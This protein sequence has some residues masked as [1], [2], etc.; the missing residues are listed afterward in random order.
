MTITLVAPC[1][2]GAECPKQVLSLELAIRIVRAHGPYTGDTE[3]EAKI[4]AFIAFFTET[5]PKFNPVQFRKDCER[6]S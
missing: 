3:Q 4:D 5:Y 1:P 6:A 2:M